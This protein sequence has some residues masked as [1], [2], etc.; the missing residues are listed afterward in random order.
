MDLT[1]GLRLGGGP[2]VVHH[3]AFKFAQA[4]H[5][6]HS[7]FTSDAMPYYIQSYCFSRA[8][9]RDGIFV[10]VLEPFSSCGPNTSS[11]AP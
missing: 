8:T 2:Q 6:E 9:N 3:R 4:C 5:S 7:T 11:R 10:P 1:H